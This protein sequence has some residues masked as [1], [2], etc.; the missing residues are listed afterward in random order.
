MQRAVGFGSRPEPSD[1]PFPFTGQTAVELSPQETS[2]LDE[3][4]NLLLNAP[5]NEE[6]LQAVW[7]AF[8]QASC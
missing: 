6:V 5:G 1:T 8:Q 4:I 7:H 3:L 2:A